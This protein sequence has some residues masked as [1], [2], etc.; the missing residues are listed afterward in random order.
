M[1][2]GMDPYNAPAWE[3]YV[4]IFLHHTLLWGVMQQYCCISTD[5]GGEIQL[6]IL[7]IRLHEGCYAELLWEESAK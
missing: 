7:P 1:V 2:L 4:E 6:R 5:V 3:T